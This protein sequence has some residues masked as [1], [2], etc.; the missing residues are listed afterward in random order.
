MCALSAL[1][2]SSSSGSGKLMPGW[3]RSPPS[4][5]AKREKK[6]PFNLCPVQTESHTA[7]RPH[8]AMDS[9]TRDAFTLIRV[10]AQSCTSCQTPRDNHVVCGQHSDRPCLQRLRLRPGD[11]KLHL[12]FHFRFMRLSHQKRLRKAGRC[13]LPAPSQ[14]CP[15]LSRKRPPA[16]TSFPTA[17]TC[18]SMLTHNSSC[19]LDFAPNTS[20]LLLLGQHLRSPALSDIGVWRAGVGAA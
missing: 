11:S 9:Q 3:T 16:G 7:H 13:H 2:R 17:K 12:W 4:S 14:P 10:T 1:P 20:F 18:R 8:F 15:A 5:S 6:T 19:A